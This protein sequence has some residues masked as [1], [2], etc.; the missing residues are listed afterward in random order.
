M[1]P[2]TKA[3][4][5][6]S[7]TAPTAMITTDPIPAGAVEIVS[8]R[9]RFATH[10]SL[11]DGKAMAVIS[12]GPV[13]YLDGAS[14]WQ[15]I[16]TQMVPDSLTSYRNA[17]N[18]F[19]IEAGD[20]ATSAPV[21][22]S[23]RDWKVS[24]DLQ[25]ASDGEPIVTGNDASYVGTSTTLAYTSVPQGLK[26]TIY[27][28]SADAPDSYTFSVDTSGC[29]VTGDAQAGYFL[30]QLG[31]PDAVGEIDPLVV[32]DSSTPATTCAGAT[33]QVTPTASGA[34]VSY[35]IPRAWIDDPARV[36]P[37]VVDPGVTVA[38]TADTWVYAGVPSGNYNTDT[39]LDIGN[40]G[41]SSTGWYRSF[42]RFDLTGLYGLNI[43]SATM[44][45]YYAGW[46]N[47][48]TINCLVEEPPTDWNS[49]AVT[50]GTQ[51]NLT[52]ST[53]VTS[54]TVGGTTQKW[55]Y[56]D[57]TPAVNY[58]I[59]NTT[60]SLQT[61][62]GF[63]L[64]TS[65]GTAGYSH[66]YQFVSAND[67]YSPH[68]PQISVTYDQ[69]SVSADAVPTGTITAD[70]SSTTTLTV[71]AGYQL[72]AG[73]PGASMIRSV[74]VVAN[75]TSPAEEVGE[76]DWSDITGSGAL[77]PH[78]VISGI[79]TNWSM[80]TDASGTRV[81]SLGFTHSSSYPSA[82]HVNYEVLGIDT[83]ASSSM[84]G[85]IQ[86]AGWGY[87]TPWQLGG[88]LQVLPAALTISSSS[89]SVASL[90]PMYQPTDTDADGVVDKRI[91]CG[92]APAPSRAATTSTSRTAINSIGW[93][94]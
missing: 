24:L 52:G 30:R 25:G 66:Y 10:Y 6:A 28:A 34:T 50:W 13:H 55:D 91:S 12:A 58:Y 32:S 27:L 4:V 45:L 49:S 15:N 77:T 79:S 90:T 14:K 53:L 22:V 41:S 37:I 16:D 38:D 56:F 81:L 3:R 57:V 2:M 83:A 68:W 36:F 74:K 18:D 76:W 23:K 84:Y 40:P 17:A 1:V 60:G 19:T 80:S 64:R 73:F 7:S 35:H 88:N 78:N 69:P 8:K 47:S 21:S 51:P 31:S 63:R 5:N 89:S 33:M 93:R 46:A 59:G 65:E 85:A 11:P 71:R 29:A 9:S 75:A 26:E 39:R 72:P 44:D 48:S 20:D 86:Y 94:R 92:R 61:N 82:Q 87:D 62:K 70:G 42:V 43:D 67:S 54:Q